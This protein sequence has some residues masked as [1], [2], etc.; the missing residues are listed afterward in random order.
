M[1][2]KR[3]DVSDATR[4]AEREEAAAAHVPDRPPTPDEE[5]AVDGRRV[6]PGVRAS[7]EEMIERGAEVEGEG[8]IP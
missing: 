3:T 7:Y 5:A 1:N 4:D 2:D 8:R 6:D